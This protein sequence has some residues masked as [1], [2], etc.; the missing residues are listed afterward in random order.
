MDRV[1]D[2]DISK[3]KYLQELHQ[4]NIDQEEIEYSISDKDFELYL[5]KNVKNKILKYSQ[6]VN[7]CD[8]KQLIPSNNDYRILLIE[9]KYNYGHWV[10][11]LRYGNTIEFFNS[12]GYSP[13]YDLDIIN[14]DTNNMLGQSQ[15]WLNNIFDN[16]PNFNI[17]YN[18]LKFQEK[19]NGVNTCGKHIIFRII[20]FK[21]YGFD[22]KQ[23]QSLMK[24]LSNKYDK[25]YDE[26][27]AIFIP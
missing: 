3:E 20:C 4:D 18:K 13:S 7:Y 27:V 24:Y 14:Q 8:I 22:L 9:T 10:C 2:S 15:K 21:K 11:V 19:V 1:I 16:S 12:Y 25:S 26:L 23:Y 5:G 17:I 6:L